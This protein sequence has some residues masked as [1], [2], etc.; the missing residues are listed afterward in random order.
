MIAEIEAVDSRLPQCGCCGRKVRRT[1][2]RTKRRLWR[3]LK[4]RH[5]P[6]VLAYTPRRVVCQDCGVRVERVPW[7]D[8]VGRHEQ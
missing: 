7:A 8:R 6:L 2:G 3:D 1:K 4:I 5:L